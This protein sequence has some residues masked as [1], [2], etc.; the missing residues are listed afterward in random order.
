MADGHQRE[1]PERREE[2]LGD[3]R[4]KL[5]VLG[6]HVAQIAGPWDVRRRRAVAAVDALLAE[7]A[8]SAP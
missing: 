7:D 8:P 4:A 5:I 6:A 2:L 3:F 1:Q